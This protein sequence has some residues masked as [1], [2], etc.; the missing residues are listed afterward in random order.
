V[1]G[2]GGA[3]AWAGV[4]RAPVAAGAHQFINFILDPGVGARLS[5]FNR[6]ATP[7]QASLPF[8]AKADRENP[9]I[10]P[11]DDVVGAWSF[12]EDV[13]P[14]ARLYDEQWTRIKAGG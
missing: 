7:N 8:I 10:Y 3:S 5:N 13:G 12:L 4:S 2:R 1:L 9:A 14:D 11:P 6:Y